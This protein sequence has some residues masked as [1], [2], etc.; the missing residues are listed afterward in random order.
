[1]RNHMAQCLRFLL[2]HR[3]IFRKRFQGI[4]MRLTLC[5]PLRTASGLPWHPRCF[6]LRRLRSMVDS[7]NPYCKNATRDEMRG[8]NTHFLF[9][10]VNM[11]ECRK[12]TEPLLPFEKVMLALSDRG[13]ISVFLMRFLR[14][15]FCTLIFFRDMIYDMI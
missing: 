10:P 3:R 2:P 14:V 4:L 6:L 1:M 13:K 11:V 8:N 7:L 12:F 15:C 9:F 5:R